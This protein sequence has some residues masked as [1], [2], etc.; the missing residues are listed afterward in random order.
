[1]PWYT[2]PEI[3]LIKTGRPINDDKKFPFFLGSVV[4]AAT[5]VDI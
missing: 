4:G 5:D 2:T 1:M 3:N